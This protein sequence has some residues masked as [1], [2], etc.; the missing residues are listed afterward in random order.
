MTVINVASGLVG[1]QPT[2]WGVL[3][4]HFGYLLPRGPQVILGDKPSCRSRK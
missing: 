3:L 2:I 1:P 4:D